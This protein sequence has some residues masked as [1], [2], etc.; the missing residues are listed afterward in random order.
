MVKDLEP[1]TWRDVYFTVRDGLRLHARHYPA[2]GSTR[3]PVLCLPGLTRNSQDFHRLAKELGDPRGHRRAVYAVDYRGRGLSEHDKDWKNYSPLIECLD[4]LDLLAMEG[5]SDCA[6]LGTSRGGLVA[7]ILALMQPAAIGTVILNDIGPE[8]ERAGLTRIIG[9][10][11]KVPVPIDWKE[12]TGIVH[13]MNRRFFTQLSE[14]DWEAFA[15]ASFLDLNGLPAPSY[16]PAIARTMSISDIANGI[17]TMWPQFDALCRVPMLA[18]RGENSDVLSPETLRKMQ[19]RHKNM[20]TITVPGQGH[21]PLLID[22]P[23][24]GEIS[25]FLIDTD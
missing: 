17:P 8:I 24:I 12:A 21:A 22:E 19:D 10:V 15:R 9:Y 20:R 13:S 5:L 23:T 1:Q 14:A 18:I 3:R 11:G 16:D 4:V 6:V 25:D 2:P 7:M